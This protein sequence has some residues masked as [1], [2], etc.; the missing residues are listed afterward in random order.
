[1]GAQLGS[2]GPMQQT[3]GPPSM[4]QLATLLQSQN[5]TLQN[6][7]PSGNAFG[8]NPAVYP[9]TGS[10][11]MLSGTGMPSL[12]TGPASPVQ[13]PNQMTAGRSAG[14]PSAGPK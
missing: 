1:M 4:N 11:P 9:Q 5:G 7:T 10:V 6:T 3:Q 12:S 14:K 13:G 2:G 8:G